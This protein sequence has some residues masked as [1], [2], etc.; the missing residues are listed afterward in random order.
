MTSPGFGVAFHPLKRRIE[1]FLQ[2]FAPKD[3][4]GTGRA[5]NA[6]PAANDAVA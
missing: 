2:R 4:T 1:H 6:D 5:A 3:K